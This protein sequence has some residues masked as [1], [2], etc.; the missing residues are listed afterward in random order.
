[1]EYDRFYIGDKTYCARAGKQAFRD[2]LVAQFP[3]EEQA[4]DRYME[5]LAEA[6]KAGF[7]LAMERMLGPWQRALAKPWL[8]W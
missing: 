1:M 4:I 6:G 7:T 3:A 2:N 8:K 5:L